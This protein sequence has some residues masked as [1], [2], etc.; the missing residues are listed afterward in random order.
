MSIRT[1]GTKWLTTGT[2]SFPKLHRTINSLSFVAW[3]SGLMWCFTGSRELYTSCQKLTTVCAGRSCVDDTISPLSWNIQ[4]ATS[5]VIGVWNN[6]F[7]PP[8]DLR[9]NFK[10]RDKPLV[11]FRSTHVRGPAFLT[12]KN[13]RWNPVHCYRSS[14]VSV[15]TTVAHLI[16][17]SGVYPLR[18]NPPQMAKVER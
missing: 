16:I 9:I 7:G 13:L 5:Y 10:R 15:Y 6:Q 18:N 3:T 4:W 1:S 11:L 2:L 8:N 17:V 14:R 12:S